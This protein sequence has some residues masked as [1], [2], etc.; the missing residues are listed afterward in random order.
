MEQALIKKFCFEILGLA[1]YFYELYNF[2]LNP[3]PV[4]LSDGSFEIYFL[5]EIILL[6][7]LPLLYLFRLAYYFDW[8]EALSYFF[9]SLFKVDNSNIFFQIKLFYNAT[10]ILLSLLLFLR[11]ISG[12][13]RFLTL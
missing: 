8:G 1:F 3:P 5:R 4:F 12:I 13:Y 7:A 10:Y 11:V 2:F 6:A 9:S